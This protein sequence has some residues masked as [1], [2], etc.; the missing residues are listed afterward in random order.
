MRGCLIVDTKTV[1]F[2]FLLFLFGCNND[3]KTALAY[4]RQ[5]QD[6]YEQA[7]Y[8]SAKQ[9]LDSLKVEFPKEVSVRKKALFLMRNIELKEQERN[10]LYCDSL[11]PVR[12]AEADSLKRLFVFI[13]DPGFYSINPNAKF[14]R[15]STNEWGEMAL[16]DVY[17]GTTPLKHNRLKVTNP[18][19]EY[20]ETEAI[21][22]DGGT[23]YTFR[24]VSGT[25]YEIVTYQKGRDNGT[26]LFIYHSAGQKLKMEYLG[27]KKYP[28]VVIPDKEKQ[29]LVS[30]VDLAAVLHDIDQLK[31]EKEKAGK[32]IEYLKKKS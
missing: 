8:G 11:L 23:N 26:I 15:T 32:R 17:S 29:D 16:T 18:A 13:Q 12:Q 25:I 5:A 10:L 7:Q 4:L 9:L 6:L 20:Q 21:S 28:P 19:G 27:G 30:T 2:V 22:F 1:V 14:I 31:K 24:D 3:K